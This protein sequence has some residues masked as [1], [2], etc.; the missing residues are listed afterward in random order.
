[1]RFHRAVSLSMPVS[2]VSSGRDSGGEHGSACDQNDLLH[3][4]ILVGST[5][6][7]V[8]HRRKDEGWANGPVNPS[9]YGDNQ[10]TVVK[11]LRSSNRRYLLHDLSGLSPE[12]NVR[13]GKETGS[14]ESCF[15]SFAL[16]LELQRVGT[17]EL[18]PKRVESG[19]MTLSAAA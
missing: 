2:G 8:M 9:L 5:D 15:R 18:W 14:G 6:T 4:L 7:L 3:E 13:S 16:G 11:L 12:S 10:Q 1:V 17:G 19:R